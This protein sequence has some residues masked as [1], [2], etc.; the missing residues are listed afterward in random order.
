[1][2]FVLLWFVVTF[3]ELTSGLAM[4]K[5]A[6]SPAAIAF[7][8]RV[9]DPRSPVFEF[10]PFVPEPASAALLAL[11]AGAALRRARRG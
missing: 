7:A 5:F 8:R 1:L 11:V 3:A 2:Y 10:V 4:K 6:G 9:V